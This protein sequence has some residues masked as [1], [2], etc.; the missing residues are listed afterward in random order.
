MFM[1]IAVSKDWKKVTPI[2]KGWS[3]DKNIWS[4]RLVVNCSF[5]NG[6]RFSVLT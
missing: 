4:K 3:S 2:S 1:N 6:G 5:R